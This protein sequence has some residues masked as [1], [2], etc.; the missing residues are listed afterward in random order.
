[1]LI[2]LPLLQFQ[3][4]HSIHDYDDGGRRNRG[5]KEADDQSDALERLWASLGYVRR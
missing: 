3:G 5:G 1:M 2:F 4:K